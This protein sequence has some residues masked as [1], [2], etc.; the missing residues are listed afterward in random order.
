MN[1]VAL[2]T[3]AGI[4]PTMF[5]II[6]YEIA[7]YLQMFSVTAVSSLNSAFI[8]MVYRENIISAYHRP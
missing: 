5:F 6:N 3:H 4:L 2:I 1:H 8:D 7:I